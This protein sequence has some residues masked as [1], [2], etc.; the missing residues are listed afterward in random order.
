MNLL[1]AAALLLQD[2]TTDQL[3]EQLRSDNVEERSQ[4]REQLKRLSKAVIPALEKAAKGSDAEVVRSAQDILEY[5]R[6]APAAEAFRKIE[7]TLRKAKSIKVVFSGMWENKGEKT[8][9]QGTA[10]VKE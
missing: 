1:L 3:I 8:V 2:K 7:E 5:I 10:L 6:T 4:A 9:S